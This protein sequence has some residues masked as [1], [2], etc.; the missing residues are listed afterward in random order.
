M[1]RPGAGRDSQHDAQIRA[2]RRRRW[3]GGFACSF[4]R[5]L[6]GEGASL[7]TF[8]QSPVGEGGRLASSPLWEL[9]DWHRFACEV[10]GSVLVCLKLCA[11]IASSPNSTATSTVTCKAAAIGVTLRFWFLMVFSFVR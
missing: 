1:L 9:D 8:G 7:S 3:A 11:N 10:A 2:L 6:Q 4:R 5:R